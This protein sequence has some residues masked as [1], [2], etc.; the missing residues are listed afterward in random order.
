MHGHRVIRDE[1]DIARLHDARPRASDWLC[2]AFHPL[3][4]CRMATGPSA[5]VI[6]ATHQ[7]FGAP[8]LYVMD[9]SAVPG[10][11]AVNPQVTIMALATRAADLLA[12]RLDASV[13]VA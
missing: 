13:R 9:G 12:E 5:G 1:A 10:P 11:P 2:T 4:T 3:G 6:D 8:G 7:V